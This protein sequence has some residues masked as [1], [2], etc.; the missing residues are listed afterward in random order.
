MEEI[1]GEETSHSE[2]PAPI[3][4]TSLALP[5][6]EVPQELEAEFE[7]PSNKDQ[8]DNMDTLSVKTT[9]DQIFDESREPQTNLD[10]RKLGLSIVRNFGW[11]GSNYDDY[12]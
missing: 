6:G 7:R 4:E 5:I 3:M 9:T 10:Q 12:E 1:I 8:D 11:S 2:V